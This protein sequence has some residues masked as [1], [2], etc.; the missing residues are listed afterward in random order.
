M[1]SYKYRVFFATTH[2]E[3]V[4]A[5][6]DDEAVILA[7][8]RQIQKGNE[9]RNIISIHIFKSRPSFDVLFPEKDY[10]RQIR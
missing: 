4:Y 6:G 1:K 10:W 9:W 8:A 7:Q 5:H 2:M 3:E